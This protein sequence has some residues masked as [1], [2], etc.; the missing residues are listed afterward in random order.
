MIDALGALAPTFLLI[1][2]GYGVRAGGIVTAEAMGVV[3]RFGYFVLYPAFLFALVS[4]ADFNARGT[5]AFLVGLAAGPTVLILLG[6]ALRAPFRHD[7]GPAFTSVF[8]GSVRWNGFVL[9]AAA[10]SLYGEAGLD[11]IGIGFG[12]IV[13][14]I[15]VVCVAVLARW[16]EARAANMRAVLDQILANPLILAC[17]AGIAASVTGW[18]DLGPVTDT[19][20]LLGPAAMPVA[21]VCVGAGLNFAAVRAAGVKVATACTMKLAVAPA[22]LWGVATLCGATPLAAAV[23]AGLGATPTAAAAYTLSREMGGDAQ[24]MAAIIT[25]TTALSFVTMPIMVALTAP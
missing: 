15:N 4:D 21:L 6:L 11:L 9:L 17:A 1:A 16:G 5:G 14:L 23:A 22:L 2:L 12:P 7:S 18:S 3:N 24:L 19:I 25:A 8:Q 13:L 10:P 20:D